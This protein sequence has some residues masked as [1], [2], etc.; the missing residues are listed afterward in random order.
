MSDGGDAAT[1]LREVIA[2][3]AALVQATSDEPSEPILRPPASEAAIA[4]L[5]ERLGTHPAAIVPGLPCDLRWRGGLPGMGSRL[6]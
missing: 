4:A 6:R 2:R 5:E 3:W 1:D